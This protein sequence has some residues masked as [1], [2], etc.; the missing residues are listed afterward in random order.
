MFNTSNEGIAFEKSTDLDLWTALQSGN[1]K[2]YE[3]IYR[4][5][6]AFLLNY[7]LK[8][9]RDQEVVADT[10]QDLFVG[11]WE[12]RASLSKVDNI[13]RYLLRSLR[14]N[15]LRNQSATA[16]RRADSIPDD[17]H[18]DFTLSIEESI[19]YN[20]LKEDQVRSLNEAF[21]KLSAR[22]RE[23]IYLKYY[24]EM[25]YVQISEIMGIS[26][27]AIYNLISKGLKKLQ[28]QISDSM[29]ASFSLFFLLLLGH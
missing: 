28:N 7:G 2:A 17:Y 12:R 19:I 29:G 20:D 18:F 21:Q 16:N 26:E 3:A 1:R 9:V 5:H 11:L 14:N 6:I 22:E 4:R 10:I 27:Q 25:T 23:A 13:Q 15:L 24:S 8:F